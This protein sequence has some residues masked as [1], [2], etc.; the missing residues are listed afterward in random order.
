MA[1]FIYMLRKVIGTG[2]PTPITRSRTR[3]IT[4]FTII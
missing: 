2:Y 3:V 1:R 4:P